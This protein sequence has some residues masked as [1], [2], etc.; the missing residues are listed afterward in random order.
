MRRAQVC[1]PVHDA[2]SKLFMQGVNKVEIPGL[3]K[4]RPDDAVALSQLINLAFKKESFFKKGD[5]T[6]EQQVRDK[7]Q[8]GTFYTVECN[9][10]MMACVYLE[11]AQE[12]NAAGLAS[13]EDAG[14]IGMLAVD[15]AQQ[16]RGFGKKLMAFAEAELQRRRCKRVQLRIVNRRTELLDFYRALGYC[17][18]GTA[19]YPFPEK[20]TLPIHFINL[21]KTI[22]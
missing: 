5:R 16:G 4:A 19:P 15:P 21:E 18:T 17:E 8:S 2:E 13:G 10:T 3:R 11:V 22:S 9:G 20:T 6:D 14:Y 12:G 1:I 7:F